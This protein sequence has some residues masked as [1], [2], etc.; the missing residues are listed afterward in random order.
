LFAGVP[1][2]IHPATKL[3]A[4]IDLLPDQVG[5]FGGKEAR[6]RRASDGMREAVVRTVASLGVL[7]TSAP[8]FAAL[9]HAFGQ[10]S[11]AHGLDIR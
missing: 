7:R 9:D 10:G 8:W 2:R 3:A 5:L 6:A 4:G 11:P 1:Q